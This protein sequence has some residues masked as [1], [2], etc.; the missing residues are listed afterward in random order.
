[1]AYFRSCYSIFVYT[2]LSKMLPYLELVL[3]FISLVYK[4]SNGDSSCRVGSSNQGQA[5]VGHLIRTLEKKTFESCTFSCELEPQCFS[6][7]YMASNK[8]CELNNAS[9]DYFPDDLV[10]RKEAFY[11]EM[12]IRVYQPCGNMPCENGGTCVVSPSVHCKCLQGFSGLRCESTDI[13][14]LFS[15]AKG[16][17]LWGDIFCFPK[18]RRRL[19][20]S[21][22]CRANR[23]LNSRHFGKK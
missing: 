5:L 2:K 12:V 11:M 14:S 16:H 15:F 22:L 4:K 7:N 9:K 18:E 19:K 17:G 23:H 1:M 20:R 21:P 6:V 3:L 13:F 8:T 10:S